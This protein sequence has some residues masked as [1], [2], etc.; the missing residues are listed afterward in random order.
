MRTLKVKFKT[1]ITFL[2]Q[3]AGHGKVDTATLQDLEHL[4]KERQAKTCLSEDKFINMNEGSGCDEKA[5][6]VSEEV[7]LANNVTLKEHLEIFCNTESAKD[8]MLGADPY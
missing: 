5:D 1:N 6:S 7:M 2:E 3:V 8:K 4:W